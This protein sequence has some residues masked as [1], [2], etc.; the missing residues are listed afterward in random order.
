M[1]L[2]RRFLT[3]LG[4]EDEKVEEIITAHTETVNALKKERDDAKEEAEGIKAELA[5]LKK[6]AKRIPELEKELE[7]MKKAADEADEKNG[8]NAWKVKYD[9]KVEELDALKA[10]FDKFKS[11]TTAKETKAAKEK[12]YKAL[13]KE[14]GVS[15]KRLDA[16]IRVTDLDKIKLDKDGNIEG[17]DD[18]IKAVKEDWADFIPTETE[19]GADTATPPANTGGSAKTKDEIM[20]IKDRAE[21]QKAIAE[22]PKLFGL[23]E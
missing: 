17:K 19:K 11:D 8:E 20:A 13:L 1:A 23:E 22:N 21:R 6:D 3:A 18:H 16:V 7:E 9:A 5:Q 4:I 12:A 2:Q 15:D 14:A 10:E